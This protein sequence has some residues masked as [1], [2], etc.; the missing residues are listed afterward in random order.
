[1]SEPWNSSAAVAQAELIASAYRRLL[2]C[3]L[4]T[5]AGG[6]STAEAVFNAPFVIVSH[7]TELDPVLNYGNRRALELW[8]MDWETLVKT[9]SRY[10]AEAPNRAERARLLEAVTRDGFICDYAGVRISSKGRRFRIE[11]ATVW[12]L[13]DL[14]GAYHGQ[15]ATFDRW[16]FLAC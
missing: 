13:I 9:P 3:D 8:E 7:G 5:G 12:N 6:G 10:T 11:K 4:V 1:V 15:A 16:E 2:G 14:A